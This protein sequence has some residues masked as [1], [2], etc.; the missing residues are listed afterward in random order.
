[1]HVLKLVERWRRKLDTVNPWKLGLYIF[2]AAFL[3]RSCIV[4]GFEKYRIIETSEPVQIAQNLVRTNVFGNP[5]G[6]ETGPTAYLAPGHPFV[7]SLIYR[8][9]GFGPGAE[10]V[11]E[12]FSSAMSALQYGMLPLLAVALGVPLTA[13]V[14][15]GACGAAFP[16]FFWIETKGT[17]ENPESM[18]LLLV[19]LC[20]S[21]ALI[22]R[23]RTSASPMFG[24]VWG[25]TF[26][27]APSFVSAFCGILALWLWRIRPKFWRPL[28]TA[29]VPMLLVVAPWILRNYAELR[30][31][32]WIRDGMGLNFGIS[33]SPAASPLFDVNSRTEWFWR[34]NPFLSP[35]ERVKLKSLG[36]LAYLEARYA[37]GKAWVRTHPVEFL[38][39]TLQRMWFFWFPPFNHPLKSVFN[40]VVVIAGLL[41]LLLMVRRHVDAAAVFGLIWALYPLPYYLVHVDPRY[42][43][44]V[45]AFSLLASAYALTRLPDW[46][47][48]AGQRPACRG[49]TKAVADGRL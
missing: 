40:G 30:S 3:L 5:F 14:I 42:R 21:A 48:R 16:L 18:V 8:V 35:E 27:F 11:K 24:I 23:S 37:D 41:G 33:N 26:L 15:A 47:L 10:L 2:I 45:Y 7:L 1:M 32:F 38:R 13:G 12:L 28:L 43:Y 20:L 22:R 34:T 9:F 17:W 36:E 39:L 29:L 46:L 4:L 6:G 31:V 44:P 19:S 49:E 25:V